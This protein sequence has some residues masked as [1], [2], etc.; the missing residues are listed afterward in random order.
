VA[1]YIASSAVS[2][3]SLPLVKSKILIVDDDLDRGGSMSISG[4]RSAAHNAKYN[5]S[6]DAERVQHLME[7]VYQLA[8]VAD[9]QDNE[10]RSLQSEVTR[11]KR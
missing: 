6:N 11:L 4:A 8:K 5:C 10:I 9:D 3:L 1:G 2:W 7:A